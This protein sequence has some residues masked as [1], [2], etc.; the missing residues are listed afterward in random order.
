MGSPQIA[1]ASP[2]IKL[3]PSVDKKSIQVSVKQ[4]RKTNTAS[5]GKP[6]Y[7]NLR[8]QLDV[9]F[10]AILSQATYDQCF[11]WWSKIRR[12]TEDTTFHFDKDAAFYS[13]LDGAANS[14]QKVIP[15]TSTLG[16]TVGDKLF[17]FEDGGGGEFEIIEVA[18]IDLNVSVTAVDN[19]I[20]S[21]ASGD[22]IKNSL[23]FY[24]LWCINE[25][26]NPVKEGDIYRYQF[27][28]YEYLA[29]Y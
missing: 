18:S 22:H 8:C 21:Y 20:H 25:E 5:S 19:L 16:S 23:S 1:I 9:T 12:N 24:H 17:L 14:G 11:A 27:Q 26:Y 4:I 2:S 6:E 7:V 13:A 10:D 3:Y 28:F 15:V 29:S